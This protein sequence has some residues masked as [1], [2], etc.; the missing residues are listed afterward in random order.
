[1]NIRIATYLLSKL[2]YLKTTEN[3]YVDKQ[4]YFKMAI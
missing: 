3:K 2:K 4:K 1:M